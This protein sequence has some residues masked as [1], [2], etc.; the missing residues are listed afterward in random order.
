ML[1]HLDSLYVFVKTNNKVQLDYEAL[2]KYLIFRDSYSF[3]GN[4]DQPRRILLREITTST[5]DL[6]FFVDALRQQLY[7]RTSGLSLLERQKRLGKS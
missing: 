5:H 3:F 4:D 2:K 6:S 7:W 1:R